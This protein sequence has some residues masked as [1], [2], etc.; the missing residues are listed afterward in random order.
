L[1]I[2]KARF[3]FRRPLADGG[4]QVG[5]QDTRR[6]GFKLARYHDQL[7]IE[8]TQ[9]RENF[10]SRAFKRRCSIAWHTFRA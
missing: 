9:L 3:D 6:S 7:G 10:L 8:P 1:T 5:R 2:A 4:F